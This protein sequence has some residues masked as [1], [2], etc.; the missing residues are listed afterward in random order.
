MAESGRIG[1]VLLA[2][3]HQRITLHAG[4]MFLL[5]RQRQ[6]DEVGRDVQPVRNDEHAD[7]SDHDASG[8]AAKPLGRELAQPFPVASAVLLQ[9][10]CTAAI[11]GNVRRAVQRKPKPKLDPACASVAIPEGSSSDAPVTSPGPTARRYPRSQLGLA[12][13]GRIDPRPPAPPAARLDH[14]AGQLAMNQQRCGLQHTGHTLPQSVHN[15]IRVVRP[16]PSSLLPKLLSY[17]LRM[18]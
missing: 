4:E 13:L 1:R 17:A 8:L 16:P 7:E 9:I 15:E 18:R 2:G 3:Q 5:D 10:S 14:E 12:A 6:L 11:N